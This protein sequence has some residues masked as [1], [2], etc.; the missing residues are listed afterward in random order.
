MRKYYEIS[1]PSTATEIVFS[2]WEV[3]QPLATIVFIPAT[4]VHPL[5]YKPLLESLADSGFHVVGVHPVGHGK[6][7]KDKTDYVLDDLVTNGMDAV[8]FAI[9]KY[10]LPVVVFGSSQGGVVALAIASKDKRIAAAF[11]H[12]VLLAEL[13]SSLS[14]TTFPNFLQHVYK[15]LQGLVRFFAKV[16]PNLKLPLGFY[17]SRK[18]IS[19]EPALWYKVNSD[20]LCLTHYSL[21][22]ISSLINTNYPGV[23]DGSITCPVYVIADEGDELFTFDYTKQVYDRI[24]APHKE[25]I[26]FQFNDHMLMINRPL[27]VAEKVVSK[28]QEAVAT[29]LH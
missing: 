2:V 6:S 24:K 27:E 14:V 5:F 21:C 26:S 29:Q 7:P 20:P 15:P 10:K 9:E 23:T 3:E 18:R 25:I 8:S 1:I 11:P 4:M 28:M 19:R 22:F 13:S 16:I 17:L 12:N